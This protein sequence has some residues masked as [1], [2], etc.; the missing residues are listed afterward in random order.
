MNDQALVELAKRG[1]RNALEQLMERV[2]DKV[3][4]LAMRMLYHPENAEDATQEILI[5]VMTHLSQFRGEST[6]ST[7]VY[8][9]AC[10]YLIGIRQKS[11]MERE[12]SFDHFAEEHDKGL[13]FLDEGVGGP[14]EKL[15]EEE[16]K[17]SCSGAMLMC[18]DRDHRMAYILGK[19]MELSSAEASEV[20]QLP[21]STYR[22]RLSR[23]NERIRSFM[24]GRCGLVN[25]NNPCRCKKRVNYAVK[26]GRVNPEKPMFTSLPGTRDPRYL[27]EEVEKMDELKRAAAVF[28]SHPQYQ[29]GDR[30]TTVIR[31]L[32]NSNRYS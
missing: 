24:Q 28:R 18:L 22:K 32:V 26:L 14:H 20:L 21:S 4:R 7:W 5:R 2:Q 17:I 29:A 25:P 15:L 12:I 1:D 16:V 9:V 11:A 30:F 27:R 31:Q 10:N 8:R 19:I 13:P 23:A 6:F 3:F